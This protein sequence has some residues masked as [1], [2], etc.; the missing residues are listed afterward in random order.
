MTKLL[1]FEGG[2]GGAFLSSSLF[3]DTF[4]YY[5]LNNEWLAKNHGQDFVYDQ[6]EYDSSVSS[7]GENICTMHY[8]EYEADFE[9]LKK[10]ETCIITCN[11]KTSYR[12]FILL[13]KLKTLLNNHIHGKRG[14][15]LMDLVNWLSPSHNYNDIT[16]RNYDEYKAELK[17][18]FDDIFTIRDHTVLT[19]LIT[20]FGSNVA[21]ND[22]DTKIKEYTNNNILL[23]KEHNLMGD[24]HE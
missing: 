22:L 12:Y 11:N 2:M 20:F 16:I 9:N 1:V 5:S 18:D 3:P 23:L 8:K 15:A 7:C 10:Y 13:G 14:T 24:H 4:E 17:I 6:G 19:K 21:L